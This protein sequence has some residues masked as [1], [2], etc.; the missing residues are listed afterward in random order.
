MAASTATT[1]K[2]ASTS[3]C[4]VTNNDELGLHYDYE[5]NC[6]LID[7]DGHLWVG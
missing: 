5:T 3:N 7:R 4:P 6:M 1:K 2:K